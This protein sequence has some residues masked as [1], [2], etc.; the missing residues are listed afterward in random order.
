MPESKSAPLLELVNP[1]IPTE[2]LDAYSLAMDQALGIEK[3]SLTAISR[4]N[5]EAMELA[6]SFA[7]AFCDLFGLAVQ[8]VANSIQ[9]TRFAFMLPCTQGE[10]NHPRL[11]AP[12]GMVVNEV[13]AQRTGDALADNMD[14][15]I[16][17]ESTGEDLDIEV[18]HFGA[19]LNLTEDQVPPAKPAESSTESEEESALEIASVA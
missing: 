2:I 8:A 10:S 18:L 13:E 17:Q 14:I 3:V 4:L 9:W 16:G 6:W 15:V 19:V 5:A 11:A 1:A 12:M 7:P